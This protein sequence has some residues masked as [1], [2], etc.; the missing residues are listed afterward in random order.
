VVDTG[1]WFVFG[2][3]PVV[4]KYSQRLFFDGLLFDAILMITY[5]VVLALYGK[6]DGFGFWQWGGVTMV[7]AGLILVKTG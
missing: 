1:V 2:L 7:V 6:T 4:V 3:W 5:V